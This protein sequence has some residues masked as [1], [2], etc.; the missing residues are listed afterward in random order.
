MLVTFDEDQSNVFKS[1][2]ILGESVQPKMVRLLVKSGLVKDEKKAGYIL[3]GAT[4]F[5][6]LLSII[7]AKSFIFGSGDTPK[8]IINM[9]EFVKSNPVNLP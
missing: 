4:L 8:G 3:I 1:R 9:S 5:F 6:I 7:I 2:A